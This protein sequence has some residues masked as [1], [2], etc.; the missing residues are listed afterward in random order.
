MSSSIFKGQGYLT[1][2]LDTG[3]TTAVLATG[4]NHKILYKKPDGTKSFF[5]AVPETTF[6]TYNFAN[7][8]LNNAPGVWE[9]QTYTEI[10]TRK[11]YGD[12]FRKNVEITL[13]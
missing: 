9:F 11:A 3:L 1:I 12:I 10:G 2:K 6:L 7:A 5:V 8:D 13:E 4:T